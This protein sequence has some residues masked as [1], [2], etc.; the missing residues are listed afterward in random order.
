MKG[1]IAGLRQLMGHLSA[2][3]GTELLLRL[4]VY[5]GIM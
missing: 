3:R 4:T 2:V 1:H 5:D